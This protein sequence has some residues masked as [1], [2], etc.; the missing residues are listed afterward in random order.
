MQLP[1]IHALLP[2]LFDAT[3]AEQY[4]TDKNVFYRSIPCPKCAEPLLVNPI[5]KAFRCSRQSCKMEFS[6]RKHTFF[7]GSQLNCAQIL[8]LA[9][10]W[11]NRSSQTQCI[12]QTG[13]SSRTVTTFH[14]HFR[15]LVAS[16]LSEIDQQIGGQ[17][18]VVE[19]D[20]T[21]LGKRK[22]N[23]GHRVDGVW[24]VAGVEKT[25]QRKVFLIRVQNRKA[26]TL[27]G[28]ISRY[29]LSG[30]I[31]HTDMHKGYAQIQSSLGFIHNTVNHSKGYKNP[32]TGF[33]TNTIE[34]TNN[35]LKIMIK[36]RNRT[37]DIDDHLAEFVWRRKCSNNLWDS[38][39]EALRE[40]HYDFE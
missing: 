34:G 19:I 5:R 22:Y 15:R 25:E 1:P 17:D 13:N 20:E 14:K 32:I 27:L 18:I 28:I 3:N 11:L 7:Y 10:M 29:V 37:R 24:I 12:N 4:L 39:I 38:F 30:S 21:K 33:T 9:Y 2:I 23:R 8:H 36:P 31:V 26:D 6:Q 35:A 40:I 16:T